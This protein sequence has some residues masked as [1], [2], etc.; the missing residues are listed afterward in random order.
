MKV[1]GFN[2]LYSVEIKKM[3]M[4]DGRQGVV[5]TAGNLMVGM[6]SVVISKDNWKKIK[7][8]I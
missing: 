5:V 8:G 1:K 6:T 2:K 4:E 7:E 3:K